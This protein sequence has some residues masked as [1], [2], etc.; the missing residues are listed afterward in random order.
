VIH[1]LNYLSSVSNRLDLKEGV[2]AASSIGAQYLYALYWATTTI[3]T[4][5]YGIIFAF[6]VRFQPFV[7]NSI[8][9]RNL[10]SI[11]DIASTNGWELIFNACVIVIGDVVYG[12]VIGAISV[13][14][15]NQH[16]PSATHQRRLAQLQAYMKWRKLPADL[17]DRAA[18]YHN[19][20]WT[21]EHGSSTQQSDMNAI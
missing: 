13:N 5:G 6:S 19:H 17:R 1:Y 18:Q 4:S 7:C 9:G 8:G 15:I 16:A 12:A 20:R 11:G 3:T 2:I 21:S 14:S 10:S